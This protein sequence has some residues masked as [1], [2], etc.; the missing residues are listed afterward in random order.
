MKLRLLA[1]LRIYM[2]SCCEIFDAN[3]T[4]RVLGYVL[5]ICYDIVCCLVQLSVYL[6]PDKRLL[7]EGDGGGGSGGGCV[8]TERV[9]AAL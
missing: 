9:A 6:A 5:L 3:H 8:V 1:L 4:N 7:D 2:S